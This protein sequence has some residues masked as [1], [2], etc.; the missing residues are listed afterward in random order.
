MT[1]INPSV[2]QAIAVKHGLLFYSKT[3]MRINRAYTPKNMMAMATKITGQTFK[4]RDYISA[5]QA[6]EHKLILMKNAEAGL[7]NDDE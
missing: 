1:T 3:G 5:A 2:Y 7:V 6:I 4:P